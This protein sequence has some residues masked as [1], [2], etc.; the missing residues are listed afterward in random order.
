[1]IVLFTFLIERVREMYHAKGIVL[2]LILAA[3]KNSGI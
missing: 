3:M 2:K 1:M